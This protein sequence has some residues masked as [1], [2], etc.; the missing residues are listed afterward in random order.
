[1][2]YEGKGSATDSEFSSCRTQ[3]PRCA[4]DTSQF[5][6]GLC[7][8]VLSMNPEAKHFPGIS[9]I[10]IVVIVIPPRDSRSW[11]VRA[12]TPGRPV[13]DEVFTV[14]VVSMRTCA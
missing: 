2:E 1:M 11:N 6:L 9:L 5:V 10:S 13:T 3:V 12:R 8:A 7:V 14:T 4:L